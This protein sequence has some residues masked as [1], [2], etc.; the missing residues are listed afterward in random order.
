MT[1]FRNSL[2]GAVAALA[3]IV[4]SGAGMASAA[5]RAAESRPQHGVC[6]GLLE[7]YGHDQVHVMAVFE[8]NADTEP[9]KYSCWLDDRTPIGKTVKRI[10]GLQ[11]DT[12]NPKHYCRIEGMFVGRQGALEPIKLIDVRLVPAK[13]FPGLTALALM[14]GTANARTEPEHAAVRAAT[15][16]IAKMAV[17]DWKWP[18]GHGM[19][20]SQQ[21]AWGPSATPEQKELLQGMIDTVLDVD[22]SIV[23]DLPSLKLIAGACKSE[24]T[25][26]VKIF[27]Y[28][29]GRGTGQQFLSGAYK[30]DLPRAVWERIKSQFA[31]QDTSQEHEKTCEGVLTI[32]GTGGADNGDR[33]VRAVNIND[34]CLFSKNSED[35]RK[36][37]TVCRMGFGCEVKARVNGDASDVYYIVKVLSVRKP[38]GEIQP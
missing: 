21:P 15:D 4:G 27:D 8:D 38:K 20:E 14:T 17:H 9:N 26:M 13:K 32:N 7:Y 30:D 6:V 34:S 25:T 18:V 28:I 29:H 11:N 12:A 35:G 24:I 16:C 36:I 2:F 33:L 19:E 37:M 31:F 10:C 1:Q 23:R 5:P 22:G 3:L